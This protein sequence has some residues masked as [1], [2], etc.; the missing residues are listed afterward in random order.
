MRLAVWAAGKSDAP[1]KVA[2]GADLLELILK[3][4]EYKKQV[5]VAV[6]DRKLTK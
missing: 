3:H 2:L 4:L 5:T 1:A 6:L